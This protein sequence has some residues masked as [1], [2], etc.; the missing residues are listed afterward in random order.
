[1]FYVIE[2]VFFKIEYIPT[3]QNSNGIKL[4]TKEV[5]YNGTCIIM[6]RPK[7][8]VVGYHHEVLNCRWK[9]IHGCVNEDTNQ[10]YDLLKI[11]S[12]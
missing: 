7:P 2:F 3:N 12:I 4:Y 1:M 6:K 9:K 10:R 11:M 5:H 8:N